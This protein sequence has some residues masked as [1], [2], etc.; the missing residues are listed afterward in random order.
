M[1]RSLTACSTLVCDLYLLGRPISWLPPSV[2]QWEA[3]VGTGG[4]EEGSTQSIQSISPLLF[5][6]FLF[7]GFFCHAA[8]G[9][10]V[11]RPGIE[12]MPPAMEA[13]V[14]T[15][16]LP[17]KSLLWWFSPVVAASLLR[18]LPDGPARALVPLDDPN[19]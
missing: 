16:G 19:S 10:L 7:F 3:L 13:G 12:P 4:R 6:W 9:M 1:C 18:V 17:G 5:L 15:T 14:L 11:P 2:S 8:Y